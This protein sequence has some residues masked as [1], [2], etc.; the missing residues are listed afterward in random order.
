MGDDASDICNEYCGTGNRSPEVLQELHREGSKDQR[1]PVELI[2]KHLNQQWN[3][4][5]GPKHVAHDDRCRLDEDSVEKSDDDAKGPSM[6]I[7]RA[8]AKRMIIHYAG[9]KTR[10]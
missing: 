4:D 1:K 5:G 2:H 10:G 8:A 6:R 3:R 7:D 9:L